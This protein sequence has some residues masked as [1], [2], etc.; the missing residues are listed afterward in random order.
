MSKETMDALSRD[1][2]EALAHNMTYGRYMAWKE[3]Q[4]KDT[5]KPIKRVLEEGEA[6]ENC[7]NASRRFRRKRFAVLNLPMQS[8]AIRR[9]VRNLTLWLCLTN[10]GYLGMSDTVGCIRQLPVRRTNC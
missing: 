6:I 2:A 4:R 10:L 7:S 3:S 5:P 8:P 9:R 1:A